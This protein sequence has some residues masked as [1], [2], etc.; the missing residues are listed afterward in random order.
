M[1]SGLFNEDNPQQIQAVYRD[2]YFHDPIAGA[3]VDLKATMPW[4]DFTITGGTEDQLKVFNEAIEK[5]N[6]KTAH[7]EMSIDQMVT[8]AFVGSLVHHNN[9]LVDIIPFDYGYTTVHPN[10][11]YSEDPS[12]QIEIS[13]AV[14]EYANSKIPG[15]MDSHKRIPPDLMQALRTAKIIDLDPITTLYLPR[16]TM[17]TVQYGVSYFRRIVPIYLLER[18]LYRGTI[19]EAQRRQ[20]STLHIQAGDEDWVPTSAELQE[21]VALFQSTEMDP[22]SAT[23]ATRNSIQ[24]QEIRCLSYD[25]LVNTDAGLK[26]IGSMFKG[27][28]IEGREVKTDDSALNH[29]GEYAKIDAVIYQGKKRVLDVVLSDGTRLRPTKNHKFLTIDSNLG[30]T[31]GTIQNVDYVLKVTKPHNR[32]NEYEFDLHYPDVE[33]RPANA[34]IKLPKRM[35]PKLAYCLALILSEGY[36]SSTTLSIANSDMRILKQVKRFMKDV[37]NLNGKIRKAATET[38][39]VSIKGSPYYTFKSGHSLEYYT[40]SLTGVLEQMGLHKSSN[41]RTDTH[42]AS[43]FKEVPECI[44]QADQESQLAFLSG[45]IDGDG[46][47]KNYEHRS[48]L[49]YKQGND[50]IWRS[51]SHQIMKSIHAILGNLGYQ[52]SLY[53]GSIEDH[54]CSAVTLTW[55]ETA[56]LLPHL[57]AIKLRTKVLASS[58][59]YQFGIPGNLIYNALRSRDVTKRNEKV[60]GVRGS[61]LLDDLG[62]RVFIPGGYTNLVRHFK[63]NVSCMSYKN[64]RAGKYNELLKVIRKVSKTLYTNICILLEREYVFLKP[65]S[66]T[67]GKKVKTYDLHMDE[68]NAPLFCIENGIVTKNSAGDFWRWT[69]VSEQLSYAKMRALGINESFLSGEST[70]GTMEMA[71]SV[72][73]EDLRTYRERETRR[74]YYDKIFPLIS[75]VNNFHS[76]T[77]NASKVMASKSTLFRALNDKDN[78]LIP[79]IHWHKQLR[80]EADQDYLG[81]LS[82]LEEKGVPVPLRMWAAAGGYDLEKLLNDKESDAEMV[83]RIA[84]YK[85]ATGGSG[86][87]EGEND[88]YASMRNNPLGLNRDFGD[89]FEIVGRTK[90]GKPKYIHNQKQAHAKANEAGAKALAALADEAHL[91]ATAKKARGNK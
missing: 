74:I 73:I 65:V 76:E 52:S 45:Y 42:T 31:L 39:Q 44:L 16:T 5:L 88:E 36:F 6:L 22:I 69:D 56:R 91:R 38:E 77:Q 15:I 81:I 49:G 59:A 70:Y 14:R 24:T 55:G 80:P 19:S 71:L 53:L 9:E 11:L 29:K 62:N 34:D 37:F 78:L 68:S 10:L 60:N 17:S 7:T 61:V 82:T 1:L 23:V 48:T 40:K 12:L 2:I 50:L 67:R 75:L 85:Q 86:E 64:Y 18:V 33:M 89:D 46:G 3:A 87:G 8:G 26:T 84:E 25:T 27:K 51:T 54:E 79:E 58:R 57:K 66:I 28:H 41:L 4:S 63:D 13:D 90:T 47:T 83:K 35:T 30:L 43:Y 32:H 72:F 21:L 20:R